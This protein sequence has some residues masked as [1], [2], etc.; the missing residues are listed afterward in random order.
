MAINF[1]TLKRTYDL[2]A[3]EYEEATLR[4]LRSGW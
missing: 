3:S 2:Y 1:V 4:A